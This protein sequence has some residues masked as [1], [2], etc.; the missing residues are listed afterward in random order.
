MNENPAKL[1]AS[2]LA[3][4]APLTV[5]MLVT[6]LLVSAP[7]L[8]RS[9]APPVSSGASK[10]VKI[11]DLPQSVPPSAALHALL[12]YHGDL[13]GVSP[14]RSANSSADAQSPIAYYLQEL[15]QLKQHSSQTDGMKQLQCLIALVPDPL[16]SHFPLT[17]DNAISSLHQAFRDH[18]YVRDRQAFLWQYA[19]KGDATTATPW[20]D[21]P[22]ALLF[23]KTIASDP[24]APAASQLVLVLLVGETPTTGVHRPA[25][26]RALDFALAN[27]LSL[28]DDPASASI[29]IIGPTF[30]GTSPSLQLCLHEWWAMSLMEQVASQNKK[31]FR[32]VDVPIVSGSATQAVNQKFLSLELEARPVVEGRDKYPLKTT[33]HATVLPDVAAQELLLKHLVEHNAI[34]LERI[35]VLTEDTA[36]GATAVK[37]GVGGVRVIPFPLSLSRMRSE[38]QKSERAT[39]PSEAA[40]AK[41]NVQRRHV[42]LESESTIKAI[43]AIPTFSSVTPATADLA[44]ARILEKI[45]Q[46]EIQAVGIVATDVQDVLFLAKQVRM[47]APDV[48]LFTTE[49]EVL[50]THSDL[51]GYLRGML[52]AST[53]PQSIRVDGW[54][55]KDV[56]RPVDLAF[57]SAS[58]HGVYNAALGQLNAL[59]P[60]HQRRRLYGYQMPLSHQLGRPPLWLSVV[61]ETGMWP[62]DVQPIDRLSQ[63][64]S[65]IAANY[66]L[67]APGKAAED[68]RFSLVSVS[69]VPSLCFAIPGAAII[70]LISLRRGMRPKRGAMNQWMARNLVTVSEIETP[71]LT[72]IQFNRQVVITVSLLGIALV[73]C[74]LLSPLLSYW[75]SWLWLKDSMPF[76]FDNYL[77]PWHAAADFAILTFCLVVLISSLSVTTAIIAQLRRH[78]QSSQKGIGTSLKSLSLLGLF[79][80]LLIVIAVSL[81]PLWATPLELVLFIDRAGELT[82]GVSPT[83]P[84]VAII[85]GMLIWALCHWSRSYMVE[86]SRLVPLISSE[87][88]CS[89]EP[90]QSSPNIPGKPSK[91]RKGA[92]SVNP[93]PSAAPS[94]AATTGAANGPDDDAQSIL[95]LSTAEL[96]RKLSELRQNVEN[97]R[98]LKL[99]KQ[100][101]LFTALVLLNA[102]YLF[103]HW[104]R[105]FEGWLY[106]CSLM[107]FSWLSLALFLVLYLYIK[108][109]CE[110]LLSVLRTAAQHPIVTAFERTPQRFRDKVSEQLLCPIP[111]AND[112]NQKMRYFLKAS[113][114]LD[115]PAASQAQELVARYER[116]ARDSADRNWV[117]SAKGANADQL[118]MIKQRWQEICRLRWELA[119]FTSQHIVPK[120][121]AYWL[122][123]EN[124]STKEAKGS[125]S[126]KTATTSAAKTAEPAEPA[127]DQPA[128]TQAAAKDVWSSAAD[129]ELYLAIE[130][131]SMIRVTFVFMRCALI[132]LIGMLIAYMVALQSYP[133]VIRT[134]IQSSLT[135]ISFWVVGSLVILM[136]KFNRDEVMSR[137]GNSTPNRFQLDGTFMKPLLTYVAL[138]VLG[139]VAIQFRASRASCL[140]G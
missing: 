123:K 38:Y 47:Y 69:R 57:P 39:A 76:S 74:L 43:D 121:C 64:T 70:G 52:V 8:N 37:P 41:L 79:V 29:P 16:D 109:I 96:G 51:V 4:P 66:L 133:F 32:Q 24:A 84:M 85:A 22:S 135:W 56:D 128:Q 59:V 27:Q 54:F 122:A 130:L 68:S 99:S 17:F 73:Q 31:S 137:I 19:A 134:T 106:D 136:V 113:K 58:S 63:N 34:K 129:A 108:S 44:M 88:P 105:T 5:L 72:S 116:L 48:L 18:G 26:I 42:T 14:S 53:Y 111:D 91:A 50:Y 25:M 139:I 67:P 75:T 112:L 83:M 40:A 28:G 36:Y 46:E 127:P 82:S 117:A 138:P 124:A 107:V 71:L 7:S 125:A 2:M 33:F 15:Q 104:V 89:V 49:S 90:Q 118:A 61:T 78:V 9:S 98:S 120:L 114:G 132:A 87:I 95:Q 13:P 10:D 55:G 92:S 60:E 110:S 94:F 3:A 35:A 77:S 102:M 126:D 140:A 1:S 20:R 11:V 6:I 21:Q 81:R 119:T 86:D 103:F 101:I 131:M 12:D 80:A 45:K 65:E 100:D 93:P 115:E 23:R 30:S 62:I 97:L